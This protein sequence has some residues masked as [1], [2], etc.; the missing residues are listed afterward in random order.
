MTVRYARL[1]DPDNRFSEAE[2]LTATAEGLP[3]PVGPLAFP[4]LPGGLNALLGAA[5][6]ELAQSHDAFQLRVQAPRMSKGLPVVVFIP[7][8]GF[9]TG[10]GNARWFSAP[11]LVHDDRCVL[12][13]VNYRI[14]ILGH[15]GIDGNPLD[16]QRPLRDLAVALRWVKENI[17]LFGGDPEKITLAG[18]SAGAWYAYA[19]STL[20]ETRGL[21]RRTALIS[22]PWEPALT[23]EQ[24]RDRWSLATTSLS[25]CGGLAEASWESL[26][27]AQAS[28]AKAYAGRGMPLM[29]AVGDNLGADLHNYSAT[30][31]KLHVESLAI[32]STS[33]ECAAFLLSVPE[34]AFPE[35]AADGFTQSRFENPDAVRDW[36]D[37][38]VPGGSA[39]AR[40]VELMTLHQFRLANLELAKAAAGAGLTVYLAG[41]SVQSPLPGAGSPHCMP[42]PF[43]FDSLR[44]WNDAPML[45][46]LEPKIFATTSEALRGWFAGFIHD[47]RI[48]VAN[49][50]GT[51]FTVS[52]PLRLEFDG[53]QPYYEVP[54]ELGLVARR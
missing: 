2:P 41:F 23:V 32:L 51:P 50:Y 18:D 53:G 52:D 37:R 15:L 3:A 45:A 44:Q 21:F 8:G 46:G 12:V 38:K 28:L 19:L 30:A 48:R 20:E 31:S 14:G 6:S 10:T 24:Y 47:G 29:P 11:S 5:N 7:G 13:T 16:S 4:Q 39:K 54:S 43:L 25:G 33:E 27:R 42:M 9:T 49:E 26:L 17:L 36:V 1:S 22:L 40:M 34:T 35:E